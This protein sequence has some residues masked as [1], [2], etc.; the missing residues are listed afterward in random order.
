MRM[1]A[2]LL[3]LFVAVMFASGMVF[4]ASK[5]S[6][7]KPPEKKTESKPPEKKVE[8]K[9]DTKQPEKKSER[10]TDTK[11]PEKKSEK[12]DKK[13]DG[14]GEK[15]DKKAKVK[16]KTKTK[17]H[18]DESIEK[19][20]KKAAAKQEKLVDINS[21]SKQD[22]MKLP[23]IGDAYAEKIIKGR[24]YDNKGQLE[25]KKILPANVFSKIADKIIA[26]QKK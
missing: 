10:K 21:A 13:T 9:T 18:H 15:G 17:H 8:K 25:K 2:R 20:D 6:E 19:T 7:T 16:I 22:L 4:A 1:T 11:Q 12:A 24:P 3:A 14:K 5:K 26:K 23:G